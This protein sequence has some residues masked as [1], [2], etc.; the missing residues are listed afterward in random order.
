M[1]TNQH[2]EVTARLLALFV[3]G[4]DKGKAE[5]Y[6]KWAAGSTGDTGDEETPTMKKKRI[7]ST[8]D[9]ISCYLTPTEQYDR[10]EARAFSTKFVRR[11]EPGLDYAE[12]AM[13]I[14][15]MPYADFLRT[16]Y[17]RGTAFSVKRR[18]KYAC[19]I[20]GSKE[21]LAAHHKT[22]E[23]HGDEIHHLD[24]IQCLCRSCHEKVHAKLTDIPMETGW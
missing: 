14:Q 13:K 22:Y 6:L 8:E 9:F 5:E 10:K 2:N 11:W 18:A 3:A 15:K 20:C 12:I 23:H 7:D 4:G 24:D 19:E 16:T 1:T 17:W 21:D